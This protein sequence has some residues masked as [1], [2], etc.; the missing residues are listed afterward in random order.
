MLLGQLAQQREITLTRQHQ[1]HISRDRLNND[2]GDMIALALHHIADGILIVVR[3]GNRVRRCPLRHTG[4]T[5]D[6]ECRHA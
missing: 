6:A 2:G 5:R 1:P 4:R 3:N